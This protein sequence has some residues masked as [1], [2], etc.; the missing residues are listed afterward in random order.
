MPTRVFAF[1]L[2]RT[3]NATCINQLDPPGNP[4]VWLPG[5]WG[6]WNDAR[7][8]RERTRKLVQR[9]TYERPT[10]GWFRRTVLWHY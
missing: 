7:T 4:I 3:E 6:Q 5:L 1:E 2:T 9:L 8:T 10:S